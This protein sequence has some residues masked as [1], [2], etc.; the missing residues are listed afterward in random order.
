MRVPGGHVYSCLGRMPATISKSTQSSQRR[1]RFRD[2]MRKLN[3][4]APARMTIEAGLVVE[5]L[6]GSLFRTLAA[7]ADLDPGSQQLL[8]GGTGSGKTTEL[9]MAERW[10]EQQGQTLSIY[11]DI[12]A[13]TDLSGLNSGALL[14]GFGLHLTRAF[15]GKGFEDSLDDA[16]KAALKK[17]RSE[18]KEFAFGT[19]KSVWVPEYDGYEADFEA[20]YDA[21]EDEPGRWVT[22]SVPGKLKPPFP[23]LQR[24]IQGIRAPLDFFINAVQARSLD[25]VVIFDGL[26][27]LIS[28]DKFW[29]VVQQDF[30]A[31]RRMRV[32]VLAAAPLSVLY[33][34]GRS[35]SEHFD[36]VHHM[37]TLNSEPE[38]NTYLKS[39][40]SHR[41]GTDLLS[42]DAAELICCFSG[43]V[44]RDLVS[45]ARDAG[46]AAYVEGCERILSEHASTVIKQLG[47]S[48]RRGLGPERVKILRRLNKE[49][50]FD[51]TSN[52]N[53][54]LLVTGRVLEYSAGDFRVHPALGALILR[55]EKN[56]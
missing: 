42:A 22:Q 11:I 15:S 40:L 28:P 45:L 47:E 5:D 52:P 49:R 56:E 8:V 32:A 24:D 55:P 34:E 2:Y 10:L 35:I 7:R 16:Q 3:P 39:V 23:A 17:A 37:A 51:V 33:G 9:L 36:R 50:F 29:A 41:G 44:L 54:E 20:D 18:I 38:N 6:H 53:I 21:S 12:S 14:A 30:R 13:E 31:L 25:V 1:E 46:E 19:T 26:D 43:G 4:T 27:R 48:Y